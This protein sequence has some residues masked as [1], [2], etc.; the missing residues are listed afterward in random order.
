MA[1]AW[2]LFVP[3]RPRQK[4]NRKAMARN[5][6][7]GALFPVSNKAD[8]AYERAAVRFVREHAPPEPLDGPIVLEVRYVFAS[9]KKP[10]WT[11]PAGRGTPDVDNLDKAL[12]DVLQAA[13]VIADD[14]RVWLKVSSAA[15]G[16]PEGTRVRVYCSAEVPPEL[17]ELSGSSHE[18]TRVPSS[19]GS[20]SSSPSGTSATPCSARTS[21]TAPRN[22]SRA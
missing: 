8:A 11:V 4:G 9:P 13:G 18:T 5:P 6:K 22:R 20:E 2:E 16:E 12:S 3:I 1:A 15:W 19:V 14:S 10:R 17:L 21:R 7:T